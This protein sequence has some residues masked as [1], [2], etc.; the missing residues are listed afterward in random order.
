M[1]AASYPPYRSYQS[2][3]QNARCSALFVTLTLIA[4]GDAAM[5][6]AVSFASARRKNSLVS[7]VFPR[8]SHRQIAPFA[9]ADAG[10]RSEIIFARTHLPFSG[11]ARLRRS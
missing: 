4:S 5:A 6:R 3:I 10:I 9:F 2:T 1:S 11:S 8:I 7:T